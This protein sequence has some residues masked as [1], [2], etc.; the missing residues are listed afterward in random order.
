MKSSY[1]CWCT[2]GRISGIM[3]K[4]KSNLA[5]FWR[6]DWLKMERDT[7]EK[8]KKNKLT[9]LVEWFV[10]CYVLFIVIRVISSWTYFHRYFNYL[11]ITSQIYGFWS[12]VSPPT[13]NNFHGMVGFMQVRHS[14]RIDLIS[15]YLD[16]C[17]LFLSKWMWQ[18]KSKFSGKK[19]KNKQNRLTKKK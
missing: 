11:V 17:F 4:K 9:V 12:V 16:L 1:M 15:R 13:L 6:E 10:Y 7:V 18:I 5:L 2:G 19:K 3:T 8:G 14:L